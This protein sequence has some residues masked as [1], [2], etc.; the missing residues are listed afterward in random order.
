MERLCCHCL[1]QTVSCCVTGSHLDRLETDTAAH[2][3][4]ASVPACLFPLHAH[5]HTHHCLP[6]VTQELRSSVMAA[7]NP[8]VVLR[9]WVAQTAIRAAELG[10][11]DT[12]ASVLALLRDPYRSEGEVVLTVPPAVAAAAGRA[13]AAAAAPV[14]S[15]QQEA[16][17]CGGGDGGSCP[18]SVQLRFDGKPPAW[19]ATLCVT[20]SS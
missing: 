8:R 20:C 16:G 5:T 9:N 11:Y 19:A 2:T 3:L 13:A 14:G 12:V 1:L 18:A 4:I 6:G 7:C 17:D 10:Q 15:K